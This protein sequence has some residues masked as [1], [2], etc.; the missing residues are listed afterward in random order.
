MQR[1]FQ[2]LMPFQFP[3]ALLAAVPL[4]AY[5]DAQSA[6][7]PKGQ[8][9]ARI[10]E[11]S[12]VLFAGG[13]I[14]FATVMILSAA[15]LF[16]P[17]GLRSAIGR[18]AMIVGGGILFPLVVLSALLIHTFL[19]ASAIM[20]ADAPPAL[21]IQVAGELWWWRVSYLG[22]N[23]STALETANEIR[24]P[25]GR[26]VEFVLISDNVIHS[27]WVP[28]LAGK[29]DM[30]PGHVNRLRVRADA[31][32]VFRGQCAE[33]CGAQHANM[34]FH[35]VAQAPADYDAWFAA[36]TKPA[37]EPRDAVLQT[38]KRLFLNACSQCHAIRG[39]PAAGTLGPDLT[40]VGSRLSV[41]AGMLP[42]NAGTFGGWI[43]GNQHIKPGNR[44]PAFGGLSGEELRALAA[45][46]ESLQ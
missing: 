31:P 26:P 43:A 10:A 29:I 14:I 8:N 4:L 19:S 42:N 27:F 45:Y 3:V 22:D 39:T 21:R 44:M 30:I 6:L 16:G 17:A 23:G 32:G 41:G 38:G 12:W 11:T 34:A 28:N 1:A 9:A 46:M 36:Q 37:Q 25:A 20:R 15:A 7:D 35:V 2:P 33:Y 5:G 24:I 40:H 18:H 13:G